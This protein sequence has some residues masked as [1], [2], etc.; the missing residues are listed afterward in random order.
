M[1]VELSRCSEMHDPFDIA[2]YL[3]R[4]QALHL[5]KNF[6]GISVCCRMLSHPRIAGLLQGQI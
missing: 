5:W 6:I 1:L 2:E 3:F 4:Y